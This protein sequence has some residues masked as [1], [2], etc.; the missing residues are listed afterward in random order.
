MLE[1]YKTVIDFI[2]FFL[3]FRLDYFGINLSFGE[4]FAGLI[5]LCIAVYVFF[6]LSE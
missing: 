1:T 5:C 6:R 3:E 4:I 2:Y